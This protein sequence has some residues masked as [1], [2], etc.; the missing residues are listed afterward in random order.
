MQGDTNSKIMLPWLQREHLHK[1]ANFKIIF[2]LI[3]TNQ[4][5]GARIDPKTIEK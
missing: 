3:Q 1:T 5:N 4:K 2:E